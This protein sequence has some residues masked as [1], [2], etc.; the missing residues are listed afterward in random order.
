MKNL[1]LAIISFVVLAFFSFNAQSDTLWWMGLNGEDW[2]D[3]DNWGNEVH[4]PMYPEGETGLPVYITTSNHQVMPGG[5]HG[6][7]L[8]NQPTVNLNDGGVPVEKYLENVLYIGGW[9][10][11]DSNQQL[12]HDPN[13]SN[14]I[15]LHQGILNLERGEIRLG[16][17][18]NP[19]A[20]PRCRYLR[21]G[22]YGARGT[23]NQSG[24]K[25][26]GCTFMTF[27][28]WSP[29]SI[30]TWNLSGGSIETFGFDLG[31]E[32]T[33]I[34]N[35]TGGTLFSLSGLIDPDPEG[36]VDLGSA[37]RL[38][39]DPDWNPSSTKE[40][41]IGRGYNHRSTTTP[42][43]K[44]FP[45]VGLYNQI[46]GVADL[47][48]IQISHGPGSIGI[49]AV[50]KDAL[51]TVSGSISIGE[52]G[53]GT[54]LQTGGVF[55]ADE[56][57]R[58]GPQEGGFGELT[59]AGGTFKAHSQLFVG[60]N[61]NEGGEGNVTVV[62]RNSDEITLDGFQGENKKDGFVVYP[63]SRVSFLIDEPEVGSGSRLTPIIAESEVKFQYD[64][65]IDIAFIR[66]GTQAGGANATLNVENLPA[67]GDEVLLVESSYRI[68][69]H[70][71][72][73]R[74]K[75][76][77]N[78]WSIRGENYSGGY[79]KKLMAIYCPS[80]DPANSLP[81]LLGCQNPSESEAV[82]P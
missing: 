15:H 7:H 81:P 58:I 78:N 16:L 45:G 33:G 10:I 28:N 70:D 61:N 39:N 50:R 66:R 20:S 31:N 53:K 64:S 57:I 34:F 77:K 76:T 43:D 35:M 27:A 56:I 60:S 8:L 2:Q 18:P 79:P 26:S 29:D 25:I 47:D 51:L 1:N 71:R 24:G 32:G 52:Y 55:E 37:P 46:D 21:L 54:V 42:N 82:M 65:E 62:G 63:G 17:S 44:Y 6:S 73:N 72:L 22:S 48:Q 4:A 69:Y 49:L 13:G 67:E 40:M 41:I 80:N 59:L 9:D 5:T 23:I 75:R 74:T 14:N 19:A 36:G 30:G 38:P 11:H 68:V 3:I 12:S